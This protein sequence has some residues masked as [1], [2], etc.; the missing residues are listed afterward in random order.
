MRALIEQVIRLGKYPLWLLLAAC[1]ALCLV[2][3][4]TTALGQSS[5]VMGAIAGGMVGEGLGRSRLR[6]RSLLALFAT[7]GGGLLLADWLVVGALPFASIIGPIG[8][9]KLSTMLNFGGGMGLASLT[10]RAMGHRWPAARAV[11]VAVAA[12]AVA[13]AFSAHRDGSVARPLWLS[14]QAWAMGFDPIYAI[15]AAGV[16]LAVALPALL[17]LESRKPLP[18]LSGLFLPALVILVFL[19]TDPASLQTPPQT[20]DLDDIQDGFA[21]SSGE[22][23][24]PTSA[25]GKDDAQ[26]GQP[27][28]GQPQDGQ[29]QDG[30]PQDGQ[31]QGGQPQDGEQGGGQGSGESQPAD[32]GEDTG[33]SSSSTDPQDALEGDASNGPPE[34]VAIVILGDDYSPPSEH[35]YFR[36]EPHS[37]FNGSRMIKANDSRFDADFLDHFAVGMT[38]LDAP[39]ETHRTRIQGTVSLLTEHTAPFGIEAPVRYTPTRNPH[40]SRFVRTYAFVSLAQE[41]P[42]ENL[43]GMTAGRSDW[44]AETWTHYTEGPED[45][46]YQA[47]ARQLIAELPPQFADDP[48]AWALKIKLHI[49]ENMK[50]TRSE[51]HEDAADPTADFLFGNFTG[52]CVHSA[53]A[54]V[55]MWRSLGLPARIGTG[56]LVREEDRRGSAVMI[57]NNQAHAWPEIYLEEVGWV[58]VDIAPAENL[59][60]MSPPVDEETLQA[61]AELARDQEPQPDREPIDYALWAERLLWLLKTGLIAILAVTLLGHYTAKFWRRGRYRLASAR[62]LPRVGYRS[63]LD[64]L[65]E[66]GIRRE[67]GE[68]RERFARRVAAIAPA[69]E[70]LTAMHLSAVLGAPD[71]E[72]PPAQ[73]W[74]ESVVAVTTSLKATVPWWRRLLGWLNPFS[75]YRAR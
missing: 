18:L 10:L 25:N 46:R 13:F 53:H 63:A 24:Q 55:Y 8:A 48:F 43:L 27:Q 4:F 44:D 42:Y 35:F 14:D 38:D 16:L 56:Y 59:D 5:A 49:D 58:V 12:A 20:A 22:D 9:L 75:F 71:A 68:S 19:F 61:L 72:R 40:T 39:P 21:S 57:R 54:A 30:Q 64:R 33:D 15:M 34:P 28:D 52:Y 50:Y 37:Q 23:E 65:A 45:P 17:F 47:L 70:T 7:L 51:R 29:P 11:E 2:A 26:D 31:A 6:T 67:H 69:F 32:G 73:R 66:V 1:A 3:P 60:P 62:A 74:R 41:T 36:Q